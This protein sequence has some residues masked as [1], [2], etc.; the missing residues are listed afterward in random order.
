MAAAL[1]DSGLL[2]GTVDADEE[3]H[4]HGSADSGVTELGRILR[5][6]RPLGVLL[7]RAVSRSRSRAPRTRNFG[8]RSGVRETLS[9]RPGEK[10]MKNVHERAMIA[11][12]LL[13]APLIA[14]GCRIPI[15]AGADFRPSREFGQYTSFAWDE[16]EEHP[17]GDPRLENSPFFQQRV[18]SAVQWEFTTRGIDLI[19]EGNSDIETG[20]P[21]RVLAVHHHTSVQDH[22]E[23]YDA[24]PDAG[25]TADDWDETRV[26]Q[27]QEATFIVGLVDAQTR[28]LVW[29]G[30]A[31]VDVDRA[32]ANPEEMRRQVDAAVAKM[33]GSFPVR[34]GRV[35][36]R[37]AN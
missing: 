12:A 8:G 19:D 1:V 29:S 27:Y 17:T 9:D 26:I 21:A 10:R 23:A 30:W 13:A 25:F 2:D 28:E 14:I 36:P 22:V 20:G 6:E 7:V 33:F 24:D 5:H 31:R 3:P 4:H 15:R 11:V 32:L 16:P 18:H 34:A 37:S 35:A